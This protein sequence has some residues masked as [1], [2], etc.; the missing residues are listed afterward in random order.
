MNEPKSLEQILNGEY[1]KMSLWVEYV[2]TEEQ[3]PTSTPSLDELISAKI[4][5]SE[6]THFDAAFI[7]RE[8]ALEYNASLV[9]E[10]ERLKREHHELCTRRAELL[11]EIDQLHTQLSTADQTGYERGVIESSEKG[12]ALEK[13]CGTGIGVKVEILNLLNKKGT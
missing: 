3:P 5:K 8:V 7:C 12:D 4:M 9:E 6:G 10:V 13:R 11:G 1:S 2:P